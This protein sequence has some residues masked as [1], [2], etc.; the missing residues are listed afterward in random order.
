MRPAVCIPILSLLLASF[1][2]SKLAWGDAVVQRSIDAE[3]STVQFTISHI[4]VERVSGTIPILK[5]T[6]DL[7]GGSSLPLSATAV[8]DVTKLDSGDRD[9]D[10]SLQS[11]NYFDVKKFPEWT[12][13]ST[14][15][16]ASGPSAF[17]MDGMLTIHGVMQP[18]RLDVTILGDASH[19]RYHA[20]GRIDRR[21]FNLKGTRLD[22]VIGTFADVTLDIVLK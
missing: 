21:T 12:F 5:G 10:A 16:V 1:V 15:I 9:R 20:T 13:A 2:Q 4:F 19:P 7:P 22:P 3:K 17:G 8:L 6:I 14:R 11:P 18:E